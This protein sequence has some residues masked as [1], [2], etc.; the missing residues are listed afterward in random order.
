MVKRSSSKRAYKKRRTVRKSR[1]IRRRKTQRGGMKF[2]VSVGKGLLGNAAATFKEKTQNFADTIGAT[3]SEKADNLKGIMK[4]GI[5]K[6]NDYRDMSFQD[7]ILSQLGAAFTVVLSV[8]KMI[9]Y[10]GTYIYIAKLMISNPEYAKQMFEL[11]KQEIQAKNQELAAC[12]ET[13]LKSIKPA[14][15]GA[16]PTPAPAPEAPKEESL[17][18]ILVSRFNEFRQSQSK[19][20]ILKDIAKNLIERKRAEI[21]SLKVNQT[22]KDIYECLKT[23]L[24]VVDEKKDEMGDDVEAAPIDESKLDQ[25]QAAAETREAAPAQQTDEERKAAL[26]AANIEA[27]TAYETAKQNRDAAVNEVTKNG[28]F[29]SNVEK[30]SRIDKANAAR[31]A[32]SAA[33]QV[34]FDAARAAAAG[35]VEN[36][37][38]PKV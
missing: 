5:D 7:K 12:F 21:E 30:Q 4:S 18:D 32:A 37:I 20:Q 17:A 26:K 9:S 15:S 13:A 25:A 34:A 23:A 22:T 38:Y 2:G 6:F 36:V 27:N 19:S 35:G 8:S 33:Y 31:A 10:I 1:V 16:A 14:D 24:K 29:T 11:K 28:M 3:I